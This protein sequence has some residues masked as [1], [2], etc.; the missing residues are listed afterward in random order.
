MFQQIVHNN[1]NIRI[2]LEWP[3]HRATTFIRTKIEEV[4][5]L[6]A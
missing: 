2:Q 4:L 6:I 5:E 3:S 1:T